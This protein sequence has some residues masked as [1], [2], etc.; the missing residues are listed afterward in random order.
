MYT[1]EETETHYVISR[2]D[3]TVVFRILVGLA[4]N[5]QH[6]AQLLENLNA[7]EVTS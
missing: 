2:P 3:G 1:L 4:G 5:E 6:A 7:D